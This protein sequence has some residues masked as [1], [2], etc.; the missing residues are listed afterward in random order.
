MIDLEKPAHKY[1]RSFR[2]FV[3]EMLAIGEELWEGYVPMPGESDQD[4]V[5]RQLQ[6]EVQPSPSQV[7]D[8][9]YW[10][11]LQGQVVGRISLRHQLNEALRNYG[12]HIGY[13]VRPSYRRQGIATEMLRQILQTPKAQ[14]IGRL[15]LTCS[16]DNIG[17]NKTILTNGGV[18]EQTIFVEAIEEDRHHYWIEI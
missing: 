10:A 11:I 17:S 16:P 18:L 15:L 2:D 13:E 5:E 4:F 14:E 1:M 6:R 7:P 8:S 3:D 12:G 9:V